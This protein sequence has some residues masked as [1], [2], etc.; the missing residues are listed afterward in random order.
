MNTD[1]V[2]PEADAMAQASFPKIRGVN[3]LAATETVWKIHG[4]TQ[5][6]AV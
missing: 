1:G 2:I 5:K 6:I 3:I 4:L